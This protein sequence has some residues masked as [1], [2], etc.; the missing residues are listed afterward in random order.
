[1]ALVSCPVP[2][3]KYT[4]R[5]TIGLLLS[6][7]TV[8]TPLDSLDAS[9]WIHNVLQSSVSIHYSI[10]RIF[11]IYDFFAAKPQKSKYRWF[12]VVRFGGGGGG[13]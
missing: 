8:V 7:D 6:I 9:I 5:W 10:D 1:M 3:P 13:W 2:I 12:K 11:S 4:P